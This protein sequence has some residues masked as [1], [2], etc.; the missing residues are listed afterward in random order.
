VDFDARVT[1]VGRSS[2]EVWVQIRAEALE[3]GRARSVGNAFV[4]MVAVDR[5]GQPT[6]VPA[7]A[8]STD[9]ERRLFDEGRR[10]MEERRRTRAGS[11]ASRSDDRAGGIR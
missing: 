2:M 9:E 1:F 8:A 4:T 11:G 5:A 6:E 10:R 7:L 3:G